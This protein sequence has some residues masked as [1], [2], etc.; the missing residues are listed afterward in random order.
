M[1][2]RVF[3]N[4]APQGSKTAVVRGGKAIMFE[5]SKKLPEWRDTVMFTCK[6]AMMDVDGPLEGPVKA[7]M[8]FLMEPPRKLVRERPTTKP[9]LDKLVRAVCDAMV[10]AGVLLDDSQI[11]TLHA[12]KHYAD[13]DEPAGVSITIENL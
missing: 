8:Y 4:P 11:V 7:T 9:D 13:S 5:S 1:E 6:M 12:H 2:I 10:D 3:G